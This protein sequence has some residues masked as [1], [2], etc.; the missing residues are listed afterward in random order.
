LPAT[1]LFDL[2]LYL[3]ERDGKLIG[4]FEY[5]ADLFEPSTVQRMIGH[6]ETLLKG[7]VADPEQPVS[8]LRLLTEADRHQLLV[9][10]ND[11]KTDYPKD[12]CIHELFE[13][14]VEKTPEAIAVQFQ[15][16]E[17]TYRQLNRLANQVAHY[18]AGLGV[19]PEKLVGICVERSLEMVIG[20]LGILKAGGAYVPLDPAYPRERLEFML[21]DGQVSVL[22][23]QEWLIEDIGWKMVDGDPGEIIEDG[24]WRME[25]RNPQSS[26]LDPRIKAV[27]LNRDW[28]KI[29]QQSEENPAK[30]TTAQNLAYVI[31][32][33]G[34]TGQPKGVAIEH[35]NTI[36]LLHWARSVFT[37]EE[38]GGVQATTSIC[39]DLSIFEL[40]VP[41]SWG[42]KVIL[43]NNVLQLP[44]APGR[45]QVTLINTVPSAMT[46]LLKI[47]RLPESLRTVHLAGEPLRSDLVEQIYGGSNVNRVYDL[48]GPSETTTYTTFTLRASNKP[49]TIGRPIANSR[50]YI[51]DG[52]LEPVPVGVTGEIFIGGAGVARGYLNRSELTV[53]MFI[54]DPFREGQGG[55]LY[56]TGD[57]GRYLPDGNIEFIG[58]MDNQVKIRGYR[59]EIGEIEAVLSKHPAVKDCVVAAV[60]DDLS[61]SENPKSKTCTERS[62]S[63]K[64]PKL[65]VAYI[66][67]DDEQLKTSELRDFLKQKLPEYMIPSSF[68]VLEALPLMPNGKVNRNMLS[69]P[70]S[71]RPPLTGEFASPRTEIEELIAQTWQEILKI[72]NVG[73]YDN[74]F[75]LGGHSLFATQIVA[76]L[77]EAF[78]KDVPLRVLFDAPTI[79][80]LAQELETII[81]DGRAPELPPI[82]PVPRDGPLPLS[83]NQ[84]H[85]WGLDQM[86]PGTHFFNMPYV[87]QLT[88]YLDFDA[89]E[90]G[91][92]EIIRRHE[93]LRTVFMKVNGRPVQVINKVVDF[94]LPVSDLVGQDSTDT[95]QSAAKI[96]LEERYRAFDLSEGPLLRTKLL[97]LTDRKHILVVTM[98]H[99]ISDQWSMEIFRREIA[100]LYEAFA[101][102]KPCHL[103]EPRIQFADYAVWE[104]QLLNSGLLDNQLRYWRNRLFGRIHQ[105]NFQR[106]GIQTKG[107]FQTARQAFEVGEGVFTDIKA[108]AREEKCTTFMIFIAAVA[109]WLNRYMGQEDIGIGILIS[110]RCREEIQRTIGHFLNTVVLRILVSPNLTV[111]QVLKRVRKC[112]LSALSYQVLPF[113]QVARALEKEHDLDRSVIFKVLVNYQRHSVEPSR[114]PG[115]AFVPLDLRSMAQ[116]SE[117]T[118]TAHHVIFDVRESST[119]LTFDVTYN[120]NIIDD[121][122]GRILTKGLWQ[123]LETISSQLHRRVFEFCASN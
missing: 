110:N 75:E 71:T 109:L 97:R 29:A 31:Y 63:I 9:E 116:G 65:L 34:S 40:F 106:H 8:T 5:N 54:T 59:I 24:R 52:S 72:E 95:G 39:F 38:L 25:D 41:L 19:G 17:L 47:N 67:S 32:T 61:D 21:K 14:Q 81:R 99:I 48:Y 122:T 91:L 77:Q 100:L 12:S 83:L 23:T 115:V 84:E 112:S 73:I 90:S 105:L 20:L 89:L 64:N 87:Y 80:E 27:Y 111:K 62:R 37:R 96:I 1:S 108:L 16:K 117:V 68:V 113:E 51:L 13:A 46:E 18:L 42:G 123:I 88:G 43:V 69:V 58:R 82:V 93:A 44:S 86:M 121:R 118:F 78:N 30:R 56:R 26:I 35:R 107:S 98:H 22:I 79:A 70:D 85:L 94:R 119:K 33:S 53:E 4:F 11:T 60:N 6:F 2:S 15:G 66:V 114:T 74:F 55:Q 76:R 92:R 36:A 50:I 10:W 49:A 7:I 102:G 120:T 28:D 103:P 104:R 3:R 101:F 45:D 57:R